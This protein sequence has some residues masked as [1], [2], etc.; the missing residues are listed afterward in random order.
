MHY[1][2]KM[3]WGAELWIHKFLTSVVDG[4]EYQVHILTASPR[5]KIYMVPMG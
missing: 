1:N 3:Y 5:D 4:D 2:I